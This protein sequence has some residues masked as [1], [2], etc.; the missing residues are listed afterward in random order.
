MTKRY[1]V[2]TLRLAAHKRR[3]AALGRK[4]NMPKDKAGMRAF[5]AAGMRCA[6]PVLLTERDGKIVLKDMPSH[7]Q[8]E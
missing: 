8:R 7:K 2:R 3:R 4:L 1:A 6:E 5:L